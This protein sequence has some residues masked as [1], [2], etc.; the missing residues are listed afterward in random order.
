MV[1]GLSI[2][3]ALK[4]KWMLVRIDFPLPGDTITGQFQAEEYSEEVSTVWA[5]VPI[6]KRSAPHLQW[7]R[8]EQ[9]TAS[10]RATLWAETLVD[11]VQSTIDKLKTAR[12][13]DDALGRPPQ[14]YFI[15]GGMVYL[16]VVL[17]IGGVRYNDLWADGRVRGVT[18]DITLQKVEDTLPI[19]P[20]DPSAP[21]PSTRYRP[22]L[23]GD[24]YE[25]LALREYNDPNLGVFVRQDNLIA[26]PG[27]GDVVPMLPK[28]SFL[29]RARAPRSYALGTDEPAATAKQAL[30]DDYAAPVTVPFVRV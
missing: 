4:W 6:P 15:W 9:E 3:N 30:F 2:K 22:A 17:S 21:S 25:A 20:T 11:N 1:A 29:R 16:C 27:P 23:Q 7:V 24:T 18:F 12:K 5:T 8:G 10:F 13:R 19:A 14:Y 28:S 26:F